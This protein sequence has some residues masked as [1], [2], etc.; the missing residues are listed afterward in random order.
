MGESHVR[1]AF[2][3]IL[4]SGAVHGN[5]RAAWVS[6][7]TTGITDPEALRAS[8]GRD[9]GV[10][11]WV[12][13]SQADVDAYAALAGDDQWIHV[14]TERAAASSYGGTVVHA[15]LTLG[16]GPKFPYELTDWSA[17]SSALNYGYDRV[18]VPSPLP[19]GSRIRM[20]LAVRG[21]EMV[22]GGTR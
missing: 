20:W 17:V 11:G 4:G 21:V 1:C 15:L 2:P 7:L 22:E 6:W 16:L 5:Q 19:T 18:R 3:W 10:S 9:L 8:I 14:D 12:T 13:I